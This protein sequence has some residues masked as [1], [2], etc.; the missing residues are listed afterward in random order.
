MQLCL[1]YTEY[2]LHGCVRI[3]IDGVRWHLADTDVETI[4]EALDNVLYG[5]T[6]LTF[7]WSKLGFIWLPWVKL[8]LNLD[9]AAL[10]LTCFLLPG[11]QP[12]GLLWKVNRVSIFCITPTT[13]S[14]TWTNELIE[15]C[16]RKQVWFL[17][18]FK[19]HA[20]ELW[21][22]FLDLKF[23]YSFLSVILSHENTSTP[24]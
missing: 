13:L 12:A 21:L 19:Q 10:D 18:T 20:N 24:L 9:L 4:N 6:G 7:S 1:Y 23:K 16:D 8:L 5:I 15:Q 14:A 3:I 22:L 11:S 2:V 17:E